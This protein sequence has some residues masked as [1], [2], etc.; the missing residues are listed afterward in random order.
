[1]T[2]IRL[3]LRWALLGRHRWGYAT[4]RTSRYGTH[5]IDVHVLPPGTNTIIR[6]CVHLVRYWFVIASLLAGLTAVWTAD[7][8]PLSWQTVFLI[9]AMGLGACVWTMHRVSSDARAATKKLTGA[10]RAADEVSNSGYEAAERCWE[11]LRDVEDH[12]DRGATSPAQFRAT[13]E[14]EHSR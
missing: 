14:A 13:W 10:R 4:S 7:A 5:R 6:G 3:I 2:K 12:L 9:K 11:R 8:V 1:M